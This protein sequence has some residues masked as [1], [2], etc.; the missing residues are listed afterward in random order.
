MS[1]PASKRLLATLVF[2]LLGAAAAAQH[3]A[4]IILEKNV[5]AIESALADDSME[6]RPLF[7]AG[8]A[9]AAR[10]IEA[11]FRGLGL[12][13][14]PGNDGYRQSF[15]FITV[16]PLDMEVRL[17]GQRLADSLVIGRTALSELRWRNGDSLTLASI[18]PQENLFAAMGR[19]LHAEGNTL[20]LVDPHFAHDF[21]RARRSL[22]G[23]HSYLQAPSN[24][25]FLLH[26]GTPKRFSLRLRNRVSRQEAHNLVGLLPGRSRPGEYVVFSAHYDHLGTGQPRQG[27]SVYNGANDDASGTTAVI[28]LARYFRAR[29]GAARSLIFVAF[30]G[31]EEGGYGSRAFSTRLDP[32]SVVAM[33]NIEMIGTPSRWG[34][35][36][37]YITGFDQSDLGR[38]LQKNLE[39]TGFRFYPDPYPEQQL[40]YR[41]DN[42]TLARLGVPA[43]TLSTS[44][45][46]S[47]PYYH[48]VDDEI[49]TLDMKNMTQIIR[50][51]A[52]SMQSIVEGKDTPTRVRPE[53]LR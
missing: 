16:Q 51:I 13:T 19:Y 38:I 7:G 9:R 49:G 48:T 21:A 30:T 33:C 42:A 36:S 5:A 28:E 10:F 8:G 2:G 43:H 17:D 53:G 18:G 44:K 23:E 34:D 50:A 45:M 1:R 4:E 24:T 31:E 47:E 39:G 14:L 35:S 20:V 25:V 40:F 11:Q 41:S 15:P 27:D 3:P 22:G 52:L 37:A 6:G 12:D 32:D 29:G 46:D 26:A